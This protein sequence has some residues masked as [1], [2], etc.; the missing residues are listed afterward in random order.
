VTPHHDPV[1]ELAAD[2]AARRRMLL[3]HLTEAPD[4]LEARRQLTALLAAPA[5]D[6]ARRRGRALLMLVA[7]VCG[8]LATISLLA[9]MDV[10]AILLAATALYALA[11][12][13]W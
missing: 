7:L 4:D 12:T 5:R 11:K 10:T 9:D 8:V 2:R 6:P 13:K 3:E 1:A